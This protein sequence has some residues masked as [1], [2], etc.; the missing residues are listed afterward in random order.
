MPYLLQT[1]VTACDFFGRAWH[2]NRPRPRHVVAA[3]GPHQFGEPLEG[4]R[5]EKRRIVGDVVRSDDV[6]DCAICVS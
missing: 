4:I 6:F 2:H 5:I 3:I 1:F